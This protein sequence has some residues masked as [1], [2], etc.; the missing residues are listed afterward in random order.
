[1]VWSTI[2]NNYGT[3]L[4][5]CRKLFRATKSYNFSYNELHYSIAKMSDQRKE[6]H[7][8]L[9]VIKVLFLG[10]KKKQNKGTTRFTVHL[11]SSCSS[12][13]L[14]TNLR[15]DFSS[16]VKC[17]SKQIIL[18]SSQMFIQPKTKVYHWCDKRYFAVWKK[19]KC[20]EKEKHSLEVTYSRCTKRFSS[21]TCF[22]W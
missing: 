8:C 5:T 14:L 6:L 12:Q 11:I 9:H 13:V 10:K 4:H 1:M 22:C 2:N 15:W 16:G 21:R 7:V 17:Q 19:G 20:W 18:T 3:A